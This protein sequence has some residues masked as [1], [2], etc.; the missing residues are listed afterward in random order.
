MQRSFINAFE[1]Y[2]MLHSEKDKYRPL[3][4]CWIVGCQL[5]HNVRFCQHVCT[6]TGSQGIYMYSTDKNK[7]KGNLYLNE[8]F[9]T[10]TRCRSKT[11]NHPT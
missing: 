5:F 8:A 2:R 1:S 9:V 4:G 10:N 3:L 6:C 7:H 11:Y